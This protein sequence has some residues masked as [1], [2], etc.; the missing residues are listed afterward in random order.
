MHNINGLNC[1][2]ASRTSIMCRQCV[3]FN[4]EE[5]N[6]PSYLHLSVLAATA[7]ATVVVVSAMAVVSPPS[8]HAVV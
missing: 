7:G 3:T 1:G 2:M 8:T 4:R 5:R 6:V